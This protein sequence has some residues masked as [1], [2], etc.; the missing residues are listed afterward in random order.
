MCTFYWQK[1]L[2]I[3]Q[4]PSDILEYLSTFPLCTGCVWIV[5]AV[6]PGCEVVTAQSRSHCA[7]CARLGAPSLRHTGP[8][9]LTRI[10]TPAPHYLRGGLWS[11]NITTP[12]HSQHHC[13]IELDIIIKQCTVVT[14]HSMLE[15]WQTFAAINL[16]I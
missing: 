11:D 4:Y 13:T 9:N 5:S 12:P 1:S 14:S 7:S 2:P 6:L 15:I 10:L 16:N 8:V 3:I